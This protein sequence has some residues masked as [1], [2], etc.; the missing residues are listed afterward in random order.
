[1]KT[2]YDVQQLIKRFGTII[3]I[4]NRLAECELM[5]DEIR[6]LFQQG[7]ILNE[8]YYQAMLIIKREKELIN[9]RGGETK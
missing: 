6:E 5:E 2:M 1:M 8:Q 3:Y 9:N 4:G 7:F